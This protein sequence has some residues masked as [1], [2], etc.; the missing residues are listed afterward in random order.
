MNIPVTIKTATVS[1]VDYTATT[2][3]RG[4]IFAAGY[5]LCAYL[6]AATF[7]TRVAGTCE[8]TGDD[9]IKY[10]APCEYGNSDQSIPMGGRALIPTGISMAIPHGWYGRIAPRSGLAWKSGIDVLAGVIDADYRGDVGVIIINLGSTPFQIR[11]GDRIAQIIIERC[12]D[13]QL[14]PCQQLPETVRGDAGY[15]ST[16]VSQNAMDA[17]HRVMATRPVSRR[18][19]TV[20]PPLEDTARQIHR[21]NMAALIRAAPG[22]SEIA[23]AH[24]AN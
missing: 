2:P 20:N 9:G 11:H 6:P 24:N 13:A 7:A 3:T 17:V 14:V 5:D 16:G 12:A 15:G 23:A 8:M 19:L 1:E 18:S 10:M 22:S 4:S 21:A